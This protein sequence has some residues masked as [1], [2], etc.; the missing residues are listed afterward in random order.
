MIIAFSPVRRSER[1][2]VSVNGDVL[3]ID[4]TDI[5]FGFVQTGD[6]LPASAVDT[7]WLTGNITRNASGEIEVTLICSHGPNADQETLFPQPTMVANGAVTFPAYDPDQD[8]EAATS[9]AITVDASALMLHSDLHKEAVTREM[10]SRIRAVADADARQAML[11]ARISGALTPEQE[12]VFDASQMWVMGMKSA[13]DLAAQTGNDP[14]WPDV[15][16][17]V[18]DLAA[19]FDFN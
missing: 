19:A 12:A 17:G 6:C 8:P 18:E 3:T 10:K 14:D 1:P 11:G 2:V 15:P 9:G 16:P 7:P 5:D 13:R 4:G